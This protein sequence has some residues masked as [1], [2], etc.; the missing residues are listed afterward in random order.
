MYESYLQLSS[1]LPEF[2]LAYNTSDR[3]SEFTMTL[4]M[5][6]LFKTIVTGACV[7]EK[8]HVVIGENN[9]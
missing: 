9:G 6:Y 1:N 3:M 8:K 4:L 7:F 2:A 5:S